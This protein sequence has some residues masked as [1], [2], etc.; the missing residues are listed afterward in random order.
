[1][2]RYILVFRSR[3]GDIEWAMIHHYM[4]DKLAC[5]AARNVVVSAAWPVVEVWHS[6]RQVVWYERCATE[7]ELME[8]CRALD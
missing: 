7:M 3:D 1:M 6:S 2:R 8:E 4:S 5:A